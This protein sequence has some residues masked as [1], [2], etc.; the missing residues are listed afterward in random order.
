MMLLP[1]YVEGAVAYP[2]VT[3]VHMLHAASDANQIEDLNGYLQSR[4]EHV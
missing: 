1:C 4:S 3:E 2:T